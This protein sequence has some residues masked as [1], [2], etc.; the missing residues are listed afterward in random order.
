MIEG[1]AKIVRDQRGHVLGEARPPI[2]AA[3]LRQD[4]WWAQFSISLRR[5]RCWN[6]FTG[7]RSG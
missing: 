1:L 5:R 6:G 7:R 2:A 3:T 4:T